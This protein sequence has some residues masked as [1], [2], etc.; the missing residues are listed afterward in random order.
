MEKNKNLEKRLGFKLRYIREQKGYSQMRLA[1][2]TGLNYN[3]VGQIERAEANTTI[4]T[5]KK[6]A[7]A[8]D[9]EAKELFDFSF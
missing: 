5:L 4:K 9:V 3:Y 7:N 8:L 2:I 1:E 6:I